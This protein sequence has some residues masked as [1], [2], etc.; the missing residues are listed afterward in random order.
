MQ[1][2]AFLYMFLILLSCIL[3]VLLQVLR[4]I[5]IAI[6]AYKFN[7]NNV[8]SS[9]LEFLH[10]PDLIILSTLIDLQDSIQK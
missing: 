6:I 7:R 1:A 9:E 3:K 2:S 8:H 5:F 4:P 10:T